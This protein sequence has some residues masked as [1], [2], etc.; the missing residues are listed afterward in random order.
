M[1]VTGILKNKARV[2]SKV[3]Y[4]DVATSL[5]D[6]APKKQWIAFK[7]KHTLQD[8]NALV[9]AVPGSSLIIDGKDNLNKMTGQQ[10]IVIH[11]VLN[12][13]PPNATMPSSDTILDE[14][15]NP[16]SDAWNDL[17]AIVSKLPKQTAIGMLA[18]MIGVLNV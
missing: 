16:A 2:L 15:L 7:D 5:S 13:I 14:L 8:I 17:H 6:S 3:I 11:S 9:N 12:I 1:Q 18:K 10:Q 4:L